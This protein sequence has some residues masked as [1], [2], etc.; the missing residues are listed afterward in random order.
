MKYE[1]IQLST[2]GPVATIRLNRPER[3]NAVIEAM[4]REI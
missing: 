1:S 4:Y 2:E 3:M